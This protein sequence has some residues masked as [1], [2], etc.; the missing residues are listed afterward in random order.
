MT[1]MKKHLEEIRNTALSGE[2]S[3]ALSEIDKIIDGR[4]GYIDALRLKGNVLELRALDRAQSRGGSLLRCRDYVAARRCYEH[5]LQL[6]PGNTLALIDLGDHFRNLGAAMKALEFYEQAIALLSSGRF[7]WSRKEEIVEAFGNAAELYGELG[8]EADRV[9]IEQAQ[10]RLVA[11]MR[12]RQLRRSR[13]R[14]SAN[15]R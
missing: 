9:R 7:G 6:D 1:P 4:P 14:S 10:R 15:R 8:K 3:D 12:A 13:T 2:Y 5:I 11:Q